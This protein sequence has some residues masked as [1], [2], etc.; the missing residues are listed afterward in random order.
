MLSALILIYLSKMFL[1]LCPCVEFNV[2]SHACLLLS[3]QRRC[4]KQ[5]S[6]RRHRIAFGESLDDGGSRASPAL[7]TSDD[8]SAACSSCSSASARAGEIPG[9]VASWA[10]SALNRSC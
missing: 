1:C 5:F 4:R 10:A 6:I 2:Q 3:F 8:G 7:P 9:T